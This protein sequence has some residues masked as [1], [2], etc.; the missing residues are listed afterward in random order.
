[1]MSSERPFITIIIFT[2]IIISSMILSP[3]NGGFD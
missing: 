1:M 3:A 2:V